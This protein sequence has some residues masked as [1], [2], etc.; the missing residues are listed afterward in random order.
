M[1]V[2]SDTRPTR[3]FPFNRQQGMDVFQHIK[4]LLR[5]HDVDVH[6]DKIVVHGGCGH[7][8]G[9]ITILGETSRV[10]EFFKI[11][12]SGASTKF[13]K[14]ICLVYPEA[15]GRFM[16]LFPSYVGS[17][18]AAASLG[19]KLTKAVQSTAGDLGV[20]DSVVPESSALLLMNVSEVAATAAHKISKADLLRSQINNNASVITAGPIAAI[21]EMDQTDAGT[22]I[23]DSVKLFAVNDGG[24]VEVAALITNQDA[25]KAKSARRRVLD[26]WSDISNMLT[27][28]FRGVTV[29]VFGD[30]LIV[31]K[32]MESP[33]M[34]QEFIDKWEAQPQDE[35]PSVVVSGADVSDAR[36]QVHA[37]TTWPD[38][39]KAESWD[40]F[41][42]DR[43]R[44]T[45]KI[46]QEFCF[47]VAEADVLETLKKNNLVDDMAAVPAEV[48]TFVDLMGD[49]I[50]ACDI[51]GV[52]ASYMSADVETTSIRVGSGQ[53]A[54]TDTWS[55]DKLL[56]QMKRVC[57][58]PMDVRPEVSFA[59]PW[60]VLTNKKPN[61]SWSN[62]T[63][64]RIQTGSTIDNPMIDL[65]VVVK[66]LDQFELPP[67]KGEEQT[68][69]GET[70][71]TV[72]YQTEEISDGGET[73]ELDAVKYV[74]PQ[75]AAAA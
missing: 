54:N 1:V 59:S 52:F 39:K 25:P 45:P 62:I 40:F 10:W 3:I 13:D 14:G 4:V 74:E 64:M 58:L 17:T 60:I 12:G 5:P 6:V 48:S 21:V 7:M 30:D 53:I 67:A 35:F 34:V 49:A 42:L 18:D 26:G 73:N 43:S 24:Q 2:V 55:R 38:G 27:D 70:D 68:D 19:T 29:G 56:S 31:V 44:P 22:K 37:T 32:P 51:D 57:K 66:K 69:G 75:T 36:T 61:G 50:A 72:S 28:G 41:H 8:Q 11:T 23:W 47:V 33:A 9:S 16:A 46:D 71:E 65:T 15:E 20:L 63:A